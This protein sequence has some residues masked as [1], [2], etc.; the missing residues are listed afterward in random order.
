[1]NQMNPA[2]GL[3][4]FITQEGSLLAVKVVAPFKV[5]NNSFVV[6]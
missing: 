6:S 1:M 4:E 5:K 2:Q 3:R